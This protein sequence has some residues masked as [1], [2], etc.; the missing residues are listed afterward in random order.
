VYSGCGIQETSVRT[1]FQTSDQADE[2]MLRLQI[3]FPRGL[4][5]KLEAELYYSQVMSS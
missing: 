2:V 3:R 4:V 1:G 5:I